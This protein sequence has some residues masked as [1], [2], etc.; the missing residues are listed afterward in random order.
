MKDYEIKY[1]IQRANDLAQEM[2]SHPENEV[3][4][5]DA[6]L[7]ADALTSFRDGIHEGRALTELDRMVRN[8]IAI[9]ACEMADD[10]RSLRITGAGPTDCELLAQAL[11]FYVNDLAEPPASAK[12]A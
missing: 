9:Y 4:K 10:V 1:R 11:T 7:L 12:A 5:T 2:L 3:K 8:I 6:G